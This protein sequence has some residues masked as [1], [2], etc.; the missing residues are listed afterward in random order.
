MDFTRQKI[1]LVDDLRRKGIKDEN[2]LNAFLS[3]PREK[4]VD[5][6]LQDKAYLDHALPIGKDQTISQPFTVA[7]MTELLKINESDKI[8]E[9]G[10]GSG[11]QCAILYKAGA[12]VYTIERI[13]E[14][15][16]RSKAI[17][18]DLG[19]DIK[20]KLGDGSE[21]WEEEA[22]FDGIIFTAALKKVPVQ[23][24]KQLKLNGRMVVPLGSRTSQTMNV[25]V[26]TEE[27]DYIQRELDQFKFVPMIG[28][29]G[30]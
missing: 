13:E 9:I 30:W 10:T 24:L 2:V 6:D 11:Y 17:F 4:F 14:L 8:L 16:N 7:Y 5:P 28:K 21:G 26:R 15:H 3:V 25:L 22:P 20:Q 12:E 18:D 23:L 27:D 1:E 19:Y 29:Y